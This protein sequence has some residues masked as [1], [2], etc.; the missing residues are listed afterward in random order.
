MNGR[1]VAHLPLLGIGLAVAAA[2]VDVTGGFST[3]IGPL[4]FRVRNPDR[5]ATASVLVLLAGAWLDWAGSLRRVEQ[6]TQAIRRHAPVLAVLMALAASALG[7]RYGTF[8]AGGADSYGY[9]S[10]AD[11]WLAGSLVTA[12]PIAGIVQ[13]PEADW[14][15]SPLGYKP[16][17]EPHT[18]VPTYPPGLP[19]AMAAAK[20]LDANRGA[21]YVVPLCGGLVIWL[22]YLLAAAVGSR[23]LGVAAAALLLT[24]PSFLF[25]LFS[26]MSDVPVTAL[27]TLALVF[28]LRRTRWSAVLCG[29]AA[30]CAIAVRPNLVPL[31]LLVAGWLMVNASSIR[32]ALQRAGWFCVG[33]APGLVLVALVNARLY[34][35]PWVSGYGSLDSLYAWAHVGPNAKAYLRWL[36]E[37]QG[38]LPLGIV[39]VFL[40]LRAS[41]PT[42]VRFLATFVA[43]LWA[44]Y[45]PYLVFADWWFL[46]FLLPAMPA[47]L[48]AALV[49]WRNVLSSRLDLSI[50]R[51]VTAAAIAAS[52]FHH[53]SYDDAKV[54]WTLADGDHRYVRAAELVRNIG[55]PRPVCLSMQHSGTL[56]YYGGCLTAR[57]DWLPAGALADALAQLE[58]AGLTP[59]IVLDEW[60]QRQFADRFGLPADVSRWPFRLV[61]E[62]PHVRVFDARD[63]AEGARGTP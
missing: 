36:M 26:P 19:L 27:W 23:A 2:A 31:G 29:V 4:P 59:Y 57:Y 49:G 37:T 62:I 53:V 21:F 10:Q 8:V 9:V 35:A 54:V 33:A 60:E 24:S 16:G 39:L 22:T 38:P 28:A 58:K 43:L 47:L 55:S 48:V 34:G 52:L 45:L 32:A 51:L 5:L 14:V 61:G 41:I 30:G 63:F 18:I 13:L 15:F 6:L 17:L 40:P 50:A 56:R 7:L 1:W 3:S 25:Q 46:R 44:S 42:D 20:W 11:L 12:Q